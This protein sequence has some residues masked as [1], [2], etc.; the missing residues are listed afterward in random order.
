METSAAVTSTTLLADY[1]TVAGV[2]LP[3]SSKQST[4][5]GNEIDLQVTHVDVAPPDLAAE[6]RK[7]ETDVHDY[8]I[9]G[10][11]ETTIPFD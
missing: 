2:R 1:H 4:T 3:F 7:P 6:V 10:A 5:Q 8:T 11:T 9:E